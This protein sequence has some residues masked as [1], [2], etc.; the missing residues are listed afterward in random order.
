MEK[1]APQLT[2]CNPTELEGCAYLTTSVETD[3]RVS[4]S[5]VFVSDGLPADVVTCL[6]G[7]LKDAHFAPIAKAGK[8]TVPVS[9]TRTR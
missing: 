1:L 4:G 6:Q 5:E 2:A 7:V 9:F 8:M 3:G